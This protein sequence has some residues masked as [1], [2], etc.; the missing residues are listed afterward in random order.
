[1]AQNKRCDWHYMTGMGNFGSVITINQPLTLKSTNKTKRHTSIHVKSFFLVLLWFSSSFVYAQH[2]NFR[3][4]KPIVHFSG[5]L[6]VYYV[7]D[8]NEPQGTERQPSRF[9]HN[10]HNELQMNMGLAKIGL[11]HS[12]YR[13]NLALHTGTYSIDNYAAEPGLLKN[14]FEAN[15]G[16]SLS[17]KHHLWLDGGVFASHIGFESAISADNWT[18]TRSMLAENSPYFET[19]VRLNYS[20][21][22]RLEMTGLILNGWQRIQRIRGNSLPSFG[23]HIQYRP[24]DKAT[25]N[26]STFVGTDDPDVIRRMRYFNHFFG[27]FQ[28]T[29]T[30]GFIAGFD[31]GIQQVIKN[32]S[33]YHFWY[34]PVLVGQYIIHRNWKTAI[35]AEYYQDEWGIIIPTSSPNGFKTTG[36]SFNLDYSPSN[37]IICRLEGRWLSSREHIWVSK[38]GLTHHHYFI[39]TSIALKFGPYP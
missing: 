29:N 1:M 24:T 8:F 11:N 3:K 27:Q 15:V 10:R 9:N 23:S 22:H 39:A 12:N 20:P 38:N 16:L 25:F 6:D 14:L 30:F 28:I 37:H 17:K 2:G 21:S 31:M 36:L 33:E 34:S 18:L 35:R 26:W 19:G 7:Y 4:E 32:S 13:A 5:F